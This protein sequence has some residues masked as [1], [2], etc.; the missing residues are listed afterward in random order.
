MW[1]RTAHKENFHNFQ[2]LKKILK[3]LPANVHAG[4]SGK[5]ILAGAAKISVRAEVFRV[6]RSPARHPQLYAYANN[7]TI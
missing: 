4:Q 3:F 6:W 1:D 2:L 5:Q 7:I